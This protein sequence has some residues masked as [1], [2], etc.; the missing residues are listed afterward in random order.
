MQSNQNNINDSEVDTRKVKNLDIKVELLDEDKAYSNFIK[1]MDEEHKEMIIDEE[2]EK[3]LNE[4]SQA[5]VDEI[6]AKIEG[7]IRDQFFFKRKFEKEFDDEELDIAEE[8]KKKHHHHHHQYNRY[9][10]QSAIDQEIAEEEEQ[11][12]FE[13]E[14]EDQIHRE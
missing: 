10:N 8:E 7:E 12:R 11:K 14:I 2:K 1:K 3:L 13:K 5:I 9:G 6:I 4:A